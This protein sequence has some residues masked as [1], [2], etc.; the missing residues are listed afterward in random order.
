[1]KP[2]I[3][4]ILL[5]I[6]SLLLFQQSYSTNKVISIKLTRKIESIFHSK[7]AK[8]MGATTSIVLL[9]MTINIIGGDLEYN[10][11]KMTIALYDANGN[12]N[13][14]DEGIDFF[15]IGQIRATELYIHPSI[16]SA[17]I[18]KLMYIQGKDV[19]FKVQRISSL[20]N[21][22]ELEICDDKEIKPNLKLLST[23]PKI[24]FELLNGKREILSNYANK[25]KYVYVDIW[26]TWCPGCVESIPELKRISKKYE[27]DLIIVSL[28]YKD[29]DKEKVREF[30]K[31]K[32]IDWIVGFSTSEINFELLQDGFPYRVLFSPAGVAIATGVHPLELQKELSSLGFK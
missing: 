32:Y 29:S 21:V 25:G 12:G 1:M 5:L 30:V 13:F 8:D 26:G 22:V 7:L 18:Q 15:I 24:Y 27:P 11:T 10:Q 31:K 19:F 3:K 28:N 17:T 20:G 9:P 4:K 2:K 6:I 14:N 23:I 16:Q